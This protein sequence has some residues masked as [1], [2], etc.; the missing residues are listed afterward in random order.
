MTELLV[1]SAILITV[2]ALLRLLFRKR[3]PPGLQYALWLL[4]LLRLALPFALFPASFSAAGAITRT[5]QAIHT[6]ETAE[7]V[8]PP[9]YAESGETAP[10]AEQPGTEQLLGYVWLGGSL[11]AAIWFIAVN[12]RLSRRLRRSRRRLEHSAPIPVYM[13]DGLSSPCLY[14]LFRPAVY[15]TEQAADDPQKAEMTVAHELTHWRHRDHL[16]SFAR[17]LCLIVYWFDPF[18]WLAAWLS[19]QDGELF[20]DACTIRS[21]GE[22]RRYE[23]GRTLLE[24]TEPAVGSAGLI[25]S[26][27]TMSVGARRMRE[28]IAMIA[29][30]PGRSLPRIAAVIAVMLAAAACTFSGAAEAPEAEP[31][32]PIPTSPS[33][34]AAAPEPVEAEATAPPAPIS[35]ADAQITVVPTAVPAPMLTDTPT[36][37]PVQSAV[38][39]TPM[40]IDQTV[41]EDAAGEET[42]S[43]GG[44]GMPRTQWVEAASGGSAPS[45]QAQTA[46]TAAPADEPESPAVTPPP[47]EAEPSETEPV[48]VRD[49]RDEYMVSEGEYPVDMPST[50]PDSPP[51]ISTQEPNE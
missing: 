49:M 45:Q 47:T 23:Y 32:E 20:C 5:V 39:T 46:I 9:S 44:G 12:R 1:S 37:A 17:L 29:R 4:V 21:L 19:R 13:A 43:G 26:V 40:S 22:E 50:V 15:L 38:S 48:V 25:C 7:P 10:T 27:S 34:I 31:T 33:L 16:W 42:P 30:G 51:P 8:T 24:M 28:R 6:D 41:R 36:S 14:G 35:E 2:V 11:I 3:I 18:V